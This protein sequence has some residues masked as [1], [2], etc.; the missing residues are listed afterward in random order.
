MA[1][2]LEWYIF[3]DSVEGLCRE[4]ERRIHSSDSNTLQ[5][6]LSR[7]QAKRTACER[8]IRASLA[9]E[10]DASVSENV[11]RN[12]KRLSNSIQYLIDD[13]ERQLHS[14]DSTAYSSSILSDSVNGTA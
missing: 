12:V 13:V 11:Q 4:V 1:E 3:L 14:V 7:F 9:F 10:V 5:E 2:N 8:I 6:F